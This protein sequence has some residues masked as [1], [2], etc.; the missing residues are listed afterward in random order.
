MIR[1]RTWGLARRA[2]WVLTILLIRRHVNGL[3]APPP[4]L[5]GRPPTPPSSYSNK[6]V[7]VCQNKECCRKW[8][9][10]QSLPETILDLLPPPSTENS[11]DNYN[12]VVEISGCLSQ[13]DKGPNVMLSSSSPSEP[14]SLRHGVQGPRQVAEALKEHWQ[15]D[16]PSK[17]VAAVTVMNKA[18]L[19]MYIHGCMRTTTFCFFCSCS[20]LG[21]GYNIRVASRFFVP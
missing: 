12:D 18:R 15:M 6:K 9:L 2:L 11:N 3:S 20:F 10:S 4:P 13:C 21:H 7:L 14:L 16:V 8:S 5:W 19:G 1:T 17:L